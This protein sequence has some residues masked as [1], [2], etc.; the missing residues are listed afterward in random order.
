MWSIHLDAFDNVS[1]LLVGI[2]TPYIIIPAQNRHRKINSIFK[3]V[4]FYNFVF[5]F[6]SF[7]SFAFL[8][9]L[10]FLI[11][12]TENQHAHTDKSGAQSHKC[13]CGKNKLKNILKNIIIIQN[14]LSWKK[15]MKN[16]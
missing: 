6:L 13:V 3:M 12:N 2:S 11:Q 16:N 7:V 1:V 15:N 8:L 10:V 5:F 9:C 4:F 14:L